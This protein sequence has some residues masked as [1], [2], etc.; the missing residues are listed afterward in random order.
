MLKKTKTVNKQ[1]YC[2]EM[3]PQ[4]FSYIQN[5]LDDQTWTRQ[6]DGARAHKTRASDQFLQQYAFNFIDSKDCT[7]RPKAKT[8]M[9]WITA[10]EACY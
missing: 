10:F 7:V 4:M 1:I 5:A 8:Y 2:E 6:Q 3:C 9:S